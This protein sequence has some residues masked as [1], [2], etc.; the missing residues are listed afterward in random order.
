MPTERKFSLLFQRKRTL[1]NSANDFEMSKA[2]SYMMN[3]SYRFVIVGYIRKGGW[4]LINFVTD[5]LLPPINIGVLLCFIKKIV[6]F[7]TKLFHKEEIKLF[8]F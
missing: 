5:K 1:I 4:E 7:E 8:C 6:S 3:A 2:Q